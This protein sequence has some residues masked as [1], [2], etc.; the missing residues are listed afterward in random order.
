MFKIEIIVVLFFFVLSTC[1]YKTVSDEEHVR[2]SLNVI[3]YALEVYYKDVGDYPTTE[4]QFYPLISK[5]SE[6]WNGPYIKEK[7]LKRLS[8]DPWGNKIVYRNLSHKKQY[9]YALYSYGKNT[10]DD[11]GLKDDITQRG[12]NKEYYKSY[13]LIYYFVT[14]LVIILTIIRFKKNKR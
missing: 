6:K 13:I 7:Q 10:K 5:T 14:V 12:Y 3:S 9:S 8:V 11:L 2:L 1:S 4:E